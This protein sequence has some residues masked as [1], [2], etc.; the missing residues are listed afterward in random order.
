MIK[1]L[2][3]KAAEITHYSYGELYIR[4]AIHTNFP[5]LR[6]GHSCGMM[7]LSL[8]FT[9]IDKTDLSRNMH[10]RLLNIFKTRPQALI[11]VNV[12]QEN[13]NYYWECSSQFYFIRVNPRN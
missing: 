5:S 12:L 3:S 7:Q 9:T 13:K 6:E 8:S 1:G 4:K 10:N 11:G 2:D